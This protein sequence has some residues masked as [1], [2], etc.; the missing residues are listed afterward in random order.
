M[1][2]V[3][4]LIDRDHLSDIKDPVKLICNGWFC[5]N[6]YDHLFSPLVDPLIV[7]FNIINTNNS[8]FVKEKCLC[9]LRNYSKKRP[10]GCRDINTLRFLRKNNIE[11]YFSSCLTT[12][13]NRNN[14]TK[15][16]IY[17]KS[18]K[19]I[20][21]DITDKQLKSILKKP[22]PINR[23]IKN[24]KSRIEISHFLKSYSNMEY[25]FTTHEVKNTLTH[26]ERFR[27]AE[28]LL[29]Q[30]AEADLV[31]TSRI[32]CA[33]PCLAFHTPVILINEYDKIVS[34]V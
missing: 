17:Q 16:S 27:V 23:F 24:F 6:D 8:D 30:Y 5:L 26:G 4:Y 14:F 10:I 21:C 32:H 3:D 29:T 9:Y 1:P 25:I 13:L 11:A 2:K 28:D 22:F 33:L 18:G 15:K 34:K 12:T 19:V 31:I 7:S 20:L